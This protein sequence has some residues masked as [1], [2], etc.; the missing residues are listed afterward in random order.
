MFWPFRKPEDAM[1]MV[2]YNWQQWRAQSNI[3][4]KELLTSPKLVR[5]PGQVDKSY[6]LRAGGRRFVLMRPVVKEWLQ[7][8]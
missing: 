7:H 6:A 2:Y 1:H 4:D 3:S 5:L 8:D